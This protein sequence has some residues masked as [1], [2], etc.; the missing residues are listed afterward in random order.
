MRHRSS[1]RKRQR[2]APKPQPP[3]HLVMGFW[4]VRGLRPKQKALEYIIHTSEWDVLCVIDVRECRSVSSGIKHQ[5]IPLISSHI[6]RIGAAP[7]RG[8]SVYTRQP[9][10]I[11][12]TLTVSCLFSIDT[13]HPVYVIAVY[14]PNTRHLQPWDELQTLLALVPPNAPAFCGGDFNFRSGVLADPRIDAEGS[15]AR[16]KIKDLHLS[17]L[18]AAGILGGTYT[19]V[20]T[21]H[22][23]NGEMHYALSVPDHI[24]CPSTAIPLVH[25]AYVSPWDVGSDHSCLLLKLQ[26]PLDGR[27]DVSGSADRRWKLDPGLANAFAHSLREQ[28]AALQ[29]GGGVHADQLARELRDAVITAAARHFRCVPRPPPRGRPRVHNAARLHHVRSSKGQWM[30]APSPST[31]AA[32]L[33]SRADLNERQGQQYS[34]DLADLRA[35]VDGV[36]RMGSSF[37]GGFKKLKAFFEA[38]EVFPSAIVAPDGSRVVEPL[39]VVR[40]SLAYFEDLYKDAGDRGL[41]QFDESFRAEMEARLVAIHTLAIAQRDAEPKSVHPDDVLAAIRRLTLGTAPGDDG[42]LPELRLRWGAVPDEHLFPNS[43]PPPRRGQTFPEAFAHLFATMLQSSV[44]PQPWRLGVMMLLKK[45]PAAR[46]LD[47]FRGL[48]LASVFAKVWGNYALGQVRQGVEAFLSEEQNGFRPS[49]STEDHIL[50]LYLLGHLRRTAGGPLAV[51]FID[52]RKA[53]DSVWHP[54]LLCTLWEAGVQGGMWLLM[55]SALDNIYRTMRCPGVSPDG[56]PP[57]RARNGVPQGAVESPLQF[58]VHIQPMISAM[59][60]A[61]VGIPLDGD[62]VPVLWFADDIALFSGTS[63]TLS[64]GL[65]EVTQWCTKF[66]MRI[67]AKKSGIL[68]TGPTHEI[69]SFRNTTLPP[70]PDRPLP[71]VDSYVYLGVTFSHDWS[72][73]P[74]VT[75]LTAKLKRE[76]GRLAIIAGGAWGLKPRVATQL[77]KSFIRAPMEYGILAWLPLLPTSRF[78]A[79]EGIQTAFLRSTLTAGVRVAS[80]VIRWEL[81]ISPVAR[82]LVM[83]F[84]KALRRVVSLPPERLVRRALAQALLSNSPWARSAFLII[85]RPTAAALRAVPIDE[86][87]S[88]LPSDCDLATMTRQSTTSSRR[89]TGVHS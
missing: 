67:N 3:S 89:Q 60:A 30:M 75:N 72:F 33:A 14:W 74:H 41:A 20:E 17:D 4:N 73:I 58:T 83:R 49:R 18:A 53:Y 78:R 51:T 68:V 64:T 34:A 45:T 79:L 59:R 55:R 44:Y 21:V 62:S 82:R 46:S 23:A 47:Q 84:I 77:F 50:T 31:T 63:Q 27:P 81:G 61:G 10:S 26:S 2:R 80:A 13:T 7:Q 40:V 69:D 29:W 38:K 8:V 37:W 22:R 52:L 71:F 65:L 6:K 16:R 1:R 35:Q 66:R 19:R 15:L 25:T 76:S 9:I 54:A 88:I 86:L 42:I 5:Y 70:C 56:L 36:R 12:K 24:L 85:S 43:P 32:F 28:C 39:E 87:R 57:F 48:T 11:I